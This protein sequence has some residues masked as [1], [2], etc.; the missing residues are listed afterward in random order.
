MRKI[1]TSDVFK[2]ARMIKGGEI[3]E[4]FKKAYAAGKEK[5]ADAEKIGLDVILDLVCACTDAK[6]EGQLYDLL[7]GICEK[8]PERIGEQPL[9]ETIEDIR[10]ICEEN[11][12]INFLKSASKLGQKI[13]G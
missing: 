6:M 3:I 9:G 4:G 7:A 11:D 1:N 8:T 12:I 2:L 13:Q 5:G 10:R